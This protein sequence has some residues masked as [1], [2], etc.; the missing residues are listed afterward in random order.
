MDKKTLDTLDRLVIVA[1]SF[2]MFNALGSGMASLPLRALAAGACLMMITASSVR[3]HLREDRKT[4][5]IQVDTK[6]GIP[7]KDSSSTDK[8]GAGHGSLKF[9]WILEDDGW[10][11]EC[12]VSG[13]SYSAWISKLPGRSDT[14]Q[15]LVGTG[16]ETVFKGTVASARAGMEKA[17]KVIYEKSCRNHSENQQSKRG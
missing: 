11:T 8:D 6:D 12:T 10:K 5:S 17:M 14:W 3:L 13:R 2:T 1:A 16:D 15:I 4:E 9:E 7:E